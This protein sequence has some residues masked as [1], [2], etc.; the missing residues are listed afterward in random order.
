MRMMTKKN[1]MHIK[2]KAINSSRRQARK[3]IKMEES[4][5]AGAPSGKMR[6][7]KVMSTALD[8]ILQMP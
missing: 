7:V 6:Q 3:Q 5:R 1:P 4:R 2:V 8:K